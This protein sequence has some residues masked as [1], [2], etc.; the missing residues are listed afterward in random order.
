M[1]V[2]CMVEGTRV[3]SSGCLSGSVPR[4]MLVGCM[5]LT[6]GSARLCTVCIVGSAHF[7]TLFPMHPVTPP[8]TSTLPL[9]CRIGLALLS[10]RSQI[11]V[12]IFHESATSLKW[13]DVGASPSVPLLPVPR[14][15]RLRCPW[16]WCLSSHQE[17]RC[18][19]ELAIG[20][21]S[22][23]SNSRTQ[24]CAGHCPSAP[25]TGI[26]LRMWVLHPT[27]WA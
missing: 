18:N 23:R 8:R 19:R 13:T 10:P 2:G 15:S 1:P 12:C 11:Q 6:A 5:H 26:P 16:D 27:P 22:S 25:C 20:R 3:R 9:P 14:S 24:R 4:T 7:Q 17:T 21:F